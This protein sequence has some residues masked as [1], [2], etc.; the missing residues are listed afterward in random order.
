MANA[1]TAKVWKSTPEAP[2]G[3]QITEDDASLVGNKEHFVV[4]NNRGTVIHGPLSIATDAAHVRKGGLW[5]GTNDF[6]MM[7]P[8]T[9]T[10]PGPQQI[11]FPPI[12]VLTQLAAD[13]AFFMAFLG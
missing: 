4:S 11:P 9:I 7:I 6:L 13:T 10:T 12:F 3:L 2:S 5:T 1:Q 8:S